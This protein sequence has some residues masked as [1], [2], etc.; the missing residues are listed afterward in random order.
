[1]SQED[2]LS[3]GAAAAAAAAEEAAGK[4]P[5]QHWTLRAGP[6]SMAAQNCRP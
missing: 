2:T 3:R 5:K 4:P 1:M 6:P